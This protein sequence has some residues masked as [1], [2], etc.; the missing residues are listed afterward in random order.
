MQCTRSAS[1]P[2]NG[3]HR[4]LAAGRGRGEP[5]LQRRVLRLRH[6]QLLLLCPDAVL[7]LRAEEQCNDSCDSF[8]AGL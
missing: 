6:L 5:L 1:L 2:T 3:S 7:Q 4:V 8:Q